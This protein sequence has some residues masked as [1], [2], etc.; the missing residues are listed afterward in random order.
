MNRDKNRDSIGQVQEPI[1]CGISPVKNR[2]RKALIGNPITIIIDR[3]APGDIA[4]VRNPVLVAVLAPP[5]GSEIEIISHPVSIAVIPTQLGNRRL[6]IDTGKAQAGGLI[7]DLHACL[8]CDQVKL[9]GGNSR[10]H[11]TQQAIETRHMG[12]SHRAT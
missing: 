3:S 6:C 9:F 4:A 7:E 2:P 5:T 10:I 8:G 12:D 1:T 11:L